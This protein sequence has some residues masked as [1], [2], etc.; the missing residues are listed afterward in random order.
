MSKSYADLDRENIELQKKI[1]EL[2]HV[3]QEL[4]YS[5]KN[6]Q[7]QINDRDDL[8]IAFRN[9]LEGQKHF[10]QRIK[11]DKGAPYLLDMIAKVWSKSK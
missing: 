6:K 1:Q 9:R 8:L 10:W 3:I 7:K 11:Q 4:E 5:V 2:Q